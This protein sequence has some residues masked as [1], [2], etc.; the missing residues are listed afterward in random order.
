MNFNDCITGVFGTFADAEGGDLGLA[1]MKNEGM[2]ATDATHAIISTVVG[3]EPI[4]GFTR[5]AI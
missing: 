2:Q 4:L 1:G 3:T 5:D